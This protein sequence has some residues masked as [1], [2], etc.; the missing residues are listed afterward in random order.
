MILKTTIFWGG[1]WAFLGVFSTPIAAQMAPSPLSKIIEAYKSEQHLSFTVEYYYY[2]QL[3]D[4]EP[5]YDLTVNMVL[6]N[7]RYYVQAEVFELLHSPKGS[8]YVDKADQ[9]ILVQPAPNKGHTALEVGGLGLENLLQQ[10]ALVIQS[11]QE[12]GLEGL[13]ITAPD[14]GNS[15]IQL[16]YQKDTHLLEKVLLKVDVPP[17]NYL[18]QMDNHTKLEAFYKNYQKKTTPFPYNIH[19]FVQ[20]KNG[21]WIPTKSSRLRHKD[22]RA[23]SA[24]TCLV[25]CPHPSYI[26]QS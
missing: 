15:L 10:E 6:G 26:F 21:K 24:P 11:F 8:I 14:F 18:G 1:L 23:P 13:R 9:T 25:I 22:R 12:K 20:Q 7:Q 17:G 4:A 2:D 5:S 19:Q 16:K 3:T